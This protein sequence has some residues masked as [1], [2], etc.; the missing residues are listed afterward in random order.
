[1]SCMIMITDVLDLVDYTHL[2]HG[3][4]GSTTY[5]DIFKVK[6]LILLDLFVCQCSSLK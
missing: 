1:M 6:K 5:L 2:P 4:Q 3:S